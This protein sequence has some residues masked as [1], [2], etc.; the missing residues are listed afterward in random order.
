[1]GQRSQIPEDG[2][3]IIRWHSDIEEEISGER[4]RRFL[5][6]AKD[7]R[8]R[9]DQYSSEQPDSSYS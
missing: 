2:E 3:K 6:V 4:V 9:M 8:R 7:T 5:T 1:M